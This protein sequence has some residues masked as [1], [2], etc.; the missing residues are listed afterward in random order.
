MTRSGKVK[1]EAQKEKGEGSR[2]KEKG[3]VSTPCLRDFPS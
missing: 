1:P 2:K 3:K